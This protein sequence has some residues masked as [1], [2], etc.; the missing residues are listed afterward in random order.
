M[1]P[2]INKD[3]LNDMIELYIKV[4]EDEDEFAKYVSDSQ[5][6]EDVCKT[7]EIMFD[8]IELDKEEDEAVLLIEQLVV[9][10]P[11]LL[12][13]LYVKEDDIKN[14]LDYVTH[15][16]V[17]DIILRTI[18][19]LVSS[20][21]AESN[22]LVD[23][24]DELIDFETMENEELTQSVVLIN[25]YKLG[26][27]IP[28]LEKRI[29]DFKWDYTTDDVLSLGYNSGSPIVSIKQANE[30]LSGECD[31]F[32]VFDFRSE[33]KYIDSKELIEEFI[34]KFDN[35]QGKK[36]TND[37]LS[38]YAPKIELYINDETH[39]SF[40]NIIL[41][42]YL[43]ALEFVK[44]IDNDAYN[45]YVDVVKNNSSNELFEMYLNNEDILV[46]IEK[47]FKG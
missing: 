29:I 37:F 26:H 10:M 35:E 44:V 6:F 4:L 15:E 24:I 22:L 27:L 43:M 28:E 32:E 5:K 21:K 33:I 1:K 18:L 8:F 31:F 3:L 38:F 46:I 45:K 7:L 23:N 34:K 9:K 30:F 36:F 11:F 42:S 14:I 40:K 39:V 17:I 25:E 19:I 20:K 2:E 16:L 41:S 47:S 13:E 12:S